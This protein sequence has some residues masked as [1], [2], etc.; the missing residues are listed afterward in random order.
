M[1]TA[2]K[3]NIDTD[4]PKFHKIISDPNLPY[5]K[6]FYDQL[7]KSEEGKE[8]VYTELTSRIEQLRKE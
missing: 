7:Y 8:F 2:D 3:V 5:L 1:I 6:T 4:F